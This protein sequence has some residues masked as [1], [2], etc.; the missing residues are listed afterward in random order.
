M[1]TRVLENGESFSLRDDC[2]WS[3][4]TIVKKRKTGIHFLSERNK[5]TPIII[6]TTFGEEWKNNVL[7]VLLKR[8]FKFVEFVEDVLKSASSV[9]VPSSVT[10]VFTFDKENI[11]ANLFKN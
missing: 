1:T 8:T 9:G 4:E 11:A 6:R 5:Q 7:V 2:A 3:V 10:F